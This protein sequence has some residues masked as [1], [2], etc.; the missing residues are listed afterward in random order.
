MGLPSSGRHR[1]K[2]SEQACSLSEKL[3]AAPTLPTSRAA[4]S[5]SIWPAGALDGVIDDLRDGHAQQLAKRDWW[6]VAM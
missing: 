5:A 4:G 6:K 3:Q 1:H 2:A